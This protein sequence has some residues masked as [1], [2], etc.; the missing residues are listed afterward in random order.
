MTSENNR[1]FASKSQKHISFIMEHLHKTRSVTAD[2]NFI[3]E[4]NNREIRILAHKVV[5]AVGSSIFNE[6][7][8]GPNSVRGDIPTRSSTITSQTFEAFI[9]LFYGK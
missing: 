5:L 4:E 9:K 2:V 8:Y 3:F 7:F 6:M 1:S